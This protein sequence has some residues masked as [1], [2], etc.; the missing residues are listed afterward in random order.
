M[1][2]Q[3]FTPPSP[4]SMAF[5]RYGQ[6]PV[7][8]STGIPDISI[9]LFEIKSGKLSL[10]LSLSYHAGGIRVED[11]AT[12]EG[13]GWVLNGGAEISRTIVGLADERPAGFLH[14]TYR[15]RASLYNEYY[16]QSDSGLHYLQ[17]LATGTWDAQSDIY[18]F[19]LLGASGKFVYDTS[20]TIQYTPVDKQLVIKR[21]NATGNF[22]IADE[23]GTMYYF[24]VTDSTLGQLTTDA[25]TWHVSKIVSADKADTIAFSYMNA[26]SY[27]DKFDSYSFSIKSTVSGT[28]NCVLGVPNVDFSSQ[29]ATI[30]N[31]RQLVQQITFTNGYVKF[32]YVADRADPG[33]ERL[34]RVQLFDLND[35]L[36]K[37]VELEHSYFE[38]DYNNAYAPKYNKRL[39]L[40]EVKFKGGDSATVN[41]YKLNYN[42]LSLPPY[43]TSTYTYHLER[44]NLEMDYWGLWNGPRNIAYDDVQTLLPKNY[45]TQIAA[46]YLTIYPAANGSVITNYEQRAADRFPNPYYTQACMLQS[47]IY[48]TG[49]TTSFVY[50]N[51]KIH[52]AGTNS[53]YTGGLRVSKVI[54]TDFVS[55]NQLVKTY[56]YETSNVVSPLSHFDFYYQKANYYLLPNSNAYCGYSNFYINANPI[57]PFNSYNGSPVLYSHV[58]EYEGDTTDNTGKTEYYFDFET[59]SLYN[60]DYLNKYWNFS[61]DKSWAR[62]NLLTKNIYKRTSNNN[63]T[64]LQ[65]TNNYYT[66]IWQKA[67]KVGELC[68]QMMDGV[69]VNLQTFLDAQYY[70]FPGTDAL[71]VINYFDYAD[72]MIPLGVKKLVKT[73]NFEYSENDTLKTIKQYAYGSSY[74]LYPTQTI[75][76]TSKAGE[77]IT[78]NIKY[79]QD[80]ASIQNLTTAAS[81][82]IDSMKSRNILTTPIEMEVYKNARLVSRQRTDYKNWYGS[83]RFYPE[84]LSVQKGGYAMEQR[85]QYKSYD[86]KGNPASF[87]YINGKNISYIWDYNKALPIAQVSNADSSSI[88]YTS[89]ESDGTGNWSVESFPAVT[90]TARTGKKSY[91]LT[92]RSISKSGLISGGKYI[93]SFWSN[94]GPQVVSGTVTTR[95]GK[96]VGNW[97]YYE[98]VVNGPTVIIT[99]AGLIDEL[100]LY[101]QDAQMTSY[102]YEPLIGVSSVADANSKITYYEYDQY[103]RLLRMRDEDSNILKQYDYQYLAARAPYVNSQKRNNVTRSD[104][105]VGYVSTSVPYT[106]PAGMFTSTQSQHS[107][108]SMASDYFSAHF[109]AYANTHASCLLIYYNVIAIDNFARS[110]CT[111]GFTPSTVADTVPAGLFSSTISQADA[112]A[113]AHAALAI[114]GPSYANAHGSCTGTCNSTTCPGQDKKCINGSC[115][116]GAKIYTSS[117]WTGSQW[118]C[119]YHYFWAADG[120]TSGDYTEYSSTECPTED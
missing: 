101:P 68:E 26:S 4:E 21:N 37:E 60:A 52:T 106:V 36:V 46:W 102:T 7:S 100:R 82:A 20:Y 19:S 62:G 96:T 97:T 11:V 103:T 88:A 41:S 18:N 10:P 67:V 40:D 76:S 115:E 57:N 24:D 66:S 116:T 17:N 49:G 63:Y 113:K 118:Q 56:L 95:Q 13:L 89:F 108:D 98:H 117:V 47:I 12:P 69:N 48:P 34:Y 111:A 61:T 6:V 92:N 120:S 54:T 84:F 53:D 44:K 94:N 16:G 15:S 73:E 50:E 29:S 112:D 14:Q 30:T 51:N 107:A 31:S 83:N 45:S 71:R 2:L 35:K 81:V 119:T 23:D 55:R 70:A 90:T 39:R 28:G 59:D 74:H 77:A 64:L 87:S 114:D 93:V 25:T 1:S 78:T 91:Y 3:N 65:Q 38:S 43:R 110:N 104:C 85:I 80:K 8:Q 105:G 42:S 9:P 33:T 58:V 99:G 86:L 79:P 22:T 109:Q 32:I 75:D 72:V 5:A 27:T